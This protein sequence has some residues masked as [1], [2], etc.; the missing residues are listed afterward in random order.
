[1]INT[2]TSV[3]AAGG[4]KKIEFNRARET[5]VAFSQYRLS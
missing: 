4:A 2:K 1:M 5:V 3:G